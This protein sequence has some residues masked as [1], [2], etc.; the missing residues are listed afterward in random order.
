MRILKKY[1]KAQRVSCIRFYRHVFMICGFMHTSCHT[2]IIAQSEMFAQ[3]DLN[4]VFKDALG[5]RTQQQDE[6]RALLEDEAERGHSKAQEKL[7]EQLYKEGKIAEA[8]KWWTLA[9]N[10][11]EVYSQIDLGTVLEDEGNITAAKLLYQKAREQE[12]STASNNLALLLEKEG[13]T[14]EAIELFRESAEKGNVHGQYNLGRMFEA[15]GKEVLAKA[16]FRK[17][18]EQDHIQAKQKLRL[19]GLF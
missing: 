12:S 7:A 4:Q 11:G 5:G 15:Q 1:L 13:K 14:E 16:W 9:A 19:F 17:A 18:A 8:K 3:L 2:P 6:Q 10:Q